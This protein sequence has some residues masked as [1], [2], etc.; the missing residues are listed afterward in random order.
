MKLERTGRRAVQPAPLPAQHFADRQSSDGDLQRRRPLLL[1]L[2][3]LLVGGA[4][5]ACLATRLPLEPAPSLPVEPPDPWRKEGLVPVR[6][7][8]AEGLL[9]LS[10]ESEPGQLISLARSGNG[11]RQ[12]N[13][14]QAPV[15]LPYVRIDSRPGSA[16]L[17]FEG[18]LYPG[19]LLIEPRPSGGLGVVNW[20][21]LEDYVEGVVAAELVLWNAGKAAIQAQ[22]I[23]AR[24]YAVATIENRRLGSRRPELWDD[25][26]DQAYRGAFQPDSSAR[27]RGLDRLLHTAVLDCR[28][29]VLEFSGQVLCA[30][31]HASCGGQTAAEADVF[32]GLSGPSLSVTCEPCRQASQRSTLSAS[33]GPTGRGT[34]PASGA[35]T[36][37]ALRGGFDPA[38]NFTASRSELSSLARTLGLG[39]RLDRLM[40]VRS[41]AWQRWLDVEVSGPEGVKRI[42]LN[43][44]RRLLGYER[45]RSGRIQTTW[46]RPGERI[47]DGIY[48]NGLGS[49]HGVGLCQRGAIGYSELGLDAE[50]ILKHFYPGVRIS[51]R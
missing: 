36:H 21:P 34:Q 25:T 20:A 9:Q 30:R 4:A 19:S 2:L 37:G 40:P 23:A 27:A 33:A 50:R 42:S 31:Y 29:R 35:S 43:E 28:G 49:G 39:P 48:F 17:R 47:Q 10:I 38:W 44:L 7:A 14:G 6:L 32:L 8:K 46:P 3:L 13:A 41:D 15:E 16:G 12:T 11:V 22:A 26:R 18:R 24:S 45:L 1:V 51:Q 5:G